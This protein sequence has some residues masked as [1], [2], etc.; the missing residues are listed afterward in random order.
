ML[1]LVEASRRVPLMGELSGGRIEPAINGSWR[2]DT[3]ADVAGRH[4]RHWPDGR[5]EASFC[6][7]LMPARNGKVERYG[8]ARNT[9]QVFAE[10]APAPPTL[11][12]AT[13]CGRTPLAKA[14]PG[15]QIRQEL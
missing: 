7:G 1:G 3:S 11:G 15:V 6:R 8:E 2:I 12:D 13:G 9:G 10:G 4:R 5:R 14:P